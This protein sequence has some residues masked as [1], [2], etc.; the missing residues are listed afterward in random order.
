MKFKRLQF[1]ILFCFANSG[2]GQF[3]GGANTATSNAI[4]KDSSIIIG[5]ANNCTIER[6]RV[7]VANLNSPLASFGLPSDAI[8]PADEFGIVSLGDSGI[9]TLTFAHPIFNGNGPDFAIF[10][11]SFSDSFLELG[12]VEVSSDGIQFFRFPSDFLQTTAQQNGPYDQFGEP[13]KINNLAGKYR[14]GYGTPFDLEEMTGIIGLNVN[15]ITH[16]R[17]IDAVGSIS[18]PYGTTD[19][20]GNYIND[21]YPTPFPSGGFDLDALAVMYFS[22]INGLSESDSFQ[23]SIFPNPSRDKIQ[24]IS[25]QNLEELVLLDGFGKVV[26]R[27]SENQIDLTHLE[28]GLYQLQVRSSD[29]N[30]VI[31]RLIKQ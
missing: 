18:S 25:N 12:H 1:L 14:S 23:F 9:A 24:I 20:N 5:W 22:G 3:A 15:A 2:F 27:T 26:F 16:I 10:E 21:P 29:G 30:W 6:G 11:N 28:N 7:D 4:H 8:G 19:Q 31:Q 13:E 17:I